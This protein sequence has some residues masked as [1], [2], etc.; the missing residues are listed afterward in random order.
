M[1]VEEMALRS[2]IRQML[3]EAGFNRNTIK[4]LV[5]ETIRSIVEAQV[6]QALA[7]RREK[8]IDGIVSDCIRTCLHNEIRRT[9]ENIIQNKLRWMTF[10]VN[11]DIPTEDESKKEE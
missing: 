9:T 6:K 11:V 5:K 4:D 7:E 10:D 2:E 8:D 1:K 3:N